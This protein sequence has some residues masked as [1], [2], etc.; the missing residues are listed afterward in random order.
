MIALWLLGCVEIDAG[1]EA[2]APDVHGAAPVA[3]AGPGLRVKRG[4]PAILDGAASW[5]PDGDALTYAW[6]VVDGPG[7]ASLDGADGPRAELRAETLGAHLV[8][9]V[10]T[11]EAGRS[12]ANEAL[13]VVEV[14]PWERLEVELAWD[15]GVDLDLHLI[16]PGGVYYG[17]GDCFFG[18]PA[19]DWGAA[20]DASD[21]PELRGEADAGGSETIALQRPEE[22]VY[23]VLVHFW[24]GQGD[25]DAS[26]TVRGEDEVL[27]TAWGR[28]PGEGAVWLV[29]AVDWPALAFAE[30]GTMTTHDALGGPGYND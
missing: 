28:L 14:V 17:D 12:S 7:D 1:R 8:S 27:G 19:P 29:G 24:R 15:A 10:V 30:D 16:A 18:D 22:G 3:V 21:D 5:D 13:A 25:V 6:E 2:Q 20:D 23:T 11:D 9:L 26:V 4:E